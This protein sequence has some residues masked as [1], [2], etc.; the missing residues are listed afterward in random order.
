MAAG[1]R[2]FIQQE[3]SIVRQRHLPWHRHLAPTDQAHIR[4]GMM[5]GMK[6]AGRAQHGVGA[7]VAGDEVEW[8][9]SGGLPLAPPPGR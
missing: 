5:R 3:A 9:W 7:G 2:Q 6:R 1:R 4:N 8:L